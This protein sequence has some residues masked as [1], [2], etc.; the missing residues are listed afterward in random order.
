MGRRIRVEDWPQAKLQDTLQK[1]T[2]AKKK[3]K[4]VG[5]WL[6]W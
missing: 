1:I 3:K 2:K 4:R 6:K 5:A